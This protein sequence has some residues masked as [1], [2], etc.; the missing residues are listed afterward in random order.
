MKI[1][2]NAAT[3]TLFMAMAY[4]TDWYSF[5]AALSKI[6]DNQTPKVYDYVKALDP[7]RY[8]RIAIKASRYGRETS[9]TV[10]ATNGQLVE[11]RGRPIVELLE[12]IWDK[13]MASYSKRAG[14]AVQ[15]TSTSRFPW[16]PRAIDWLKKE[17]LL[18]SKYRS[19]VSS[20]SENEII[21][22][23]VNRTSSLVDNV[24]REV[25]LSL[26]ENTGE[27]TCLDF[28][29]RRMPCRHAQKVLAEL[30]LDFKR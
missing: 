29:D 10:E 11:L 25:R 3:E 6:K 2:T 28:Q 26:A 4:A 30:G 27:C 22:K 9:N 5:N 1:N 13:Q 7:V 20:R 23:V 16:T 15:W 21:A 18:C 24:Q 12:G 17:Q 8:A 19:T 14:E